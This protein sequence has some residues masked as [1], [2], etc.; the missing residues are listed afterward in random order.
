MV[1]DWRDI[2]MLIAGCGSIGKRH[3]RVLGT[4]GLR[5]IR[6]CDPSD[7]QRRSL[8]EQVPSVKTYDSLAAGLAD[9][10]D[11]VLICTP[12]AVHVPMAREAIEAGCHVLTEKPLSDSTDGIDALAALA[13][14][15]RKKVM[16]ALCFRYHDGLLKAKDYLDS[17]R[18]G[19]LVSVRALM[20]ESLP[21]VRPDYRSLFSAKEGGAFDLVHDV[22]LAIWYAGQPVRSVHCVCGS[23]SDIGIEV[24]RCGRDLDGFRGSLP[25]HRASGLL[26]K[27]ATPANRTDR[28]GWSH[29]RG[30]RQ[31][32]PRD[33]LGLSVPARAMGDRGIEHRSRRHVSGGR[34]RVPRSRGKRQTHPV[35]HRGR[36]QVPGNGLGRSTR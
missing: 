18:I 32:G 28:R 17:G 19:R 27:A 16:V 36:P 25:S 30:I 26:P 7:Q 8:L 21:D 2:S 6:V 4:L 10:P 3:A 35:H 29:R 9:R 14:R 5:D 20:G 33:G 23:Y 24:A 11:A 31:L 34:P 12:P 1:K 15:H 22:D 13:E